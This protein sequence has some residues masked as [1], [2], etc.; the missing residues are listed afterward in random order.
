MKACPS[1]C[2]NQHRMTDLGCPRRTQYP[3][4]NV[5]NVPSDSTLSTSHLSFPTHHLAI[6]EGVCVCACA[7]VCVCV[8]LCLCVHVCHVC[9]CIYVNV[10][11]HVCMYVYVYVCM[12]VCTTVCMHVCKYVCI[13]VY[14]CVYMWVYAC[15]TDISPYAY[16]QYVYAC[17]TPHIW[18]THSCMHACVACNDCGPSSLASAPPSCCCRQPTSHLRTLSAARSSVQ[19]G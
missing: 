6:L 11:M 7:C 15:I 18:L 8:R 5:C 3:R 2:N 10:C 16:I 13:C 4:H 9:L 17:T 19:I 14:I 12:Y 1:A